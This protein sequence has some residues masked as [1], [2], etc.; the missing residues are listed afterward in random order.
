MTK[1]IF[2]RGKSWL[3]YVDYPRDPSKPWQRNRRYFT[4][5][6]TEKDA[7]RFRRERLGE[8]DRGAQAPASKLTVAD[9]LK[10][11][12][13]DYAKPN[14]SPRTVEGY[15]GIIEKHII[16]A[17]GNIQLSQLK[18]NH[19]KAFYAETMNKGLS[20]QTVKHHH[21]L[22]SE[23]LN[24]AVI[25]GL[26]FDNPA[27]SVKAPRPEYREMPVLGID[28]V[29][30]VLDI[31]RETRHFAMIATAVY[32]GL[33]RGE[34]LAL[35]WQDIDLNKGV[36]QVNRSLHQLWGGELVYTA[37]KSRRGRRPMPLAPTLIKVLKSHR[38]KQEAYFNRLG[39]ELAS[40]NLIFMRPVDRTEV[41]PR[42]F[43]GQFKKI[44]RSIGRPDITLHSLRHTFS[45]ILMSEGYNIVEIS[46]AMG[47]ATPGFTLDQ[48]G[49]H[50]TGL[51][52]AAV[53][54]F[55]ELLQFELEK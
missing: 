4:V 2:K 19:I 46:Q 45:A 36:L 9:Y 3:V 49:H 22:L 23:T 12:L 50:L 43:S 25:D 33:R 54:R 55:D 13:R 32:T 37:P 6:G 42:Y 27:K 8:I 10:Q 52:K 28:E 5:R 53:A 26:I 47:H 39:R 17:L 34:V 35:R 41:R 24:H 16:P 38:E 29:Y 31:A 1:G 11:W 21:R 14:T 20:A 40:S 44:A 7:Q 18:T 48:Y 30:R 51:H 15:R